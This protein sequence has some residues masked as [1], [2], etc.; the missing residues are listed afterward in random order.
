MDRY[1]GVARPRRVNIEKDFVEV[2][3]IDE[4]KMQKSDCMCEAENEIA[5]S[6]SGENIVIID[7]STIYEIDARCMNSKNNKK[8]NSDNR[9]NSRNR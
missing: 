6:D 1:M 2:K 8:N 9:S 5:S 3:V 4:V 7:D